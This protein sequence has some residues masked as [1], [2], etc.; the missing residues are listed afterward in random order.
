MQS[1]L[2]GAS[3]IQ[4]VWFSP[5]ARAVKGSS[6]FE[7]LLGA[8]PDTV[9]TNRSAPPGVAMFTATS[10]I[11]AVEHTVNI[12]EGRVDYFITPLITN[13]GRPGKIELDQARAVISKSVEGAIHATGHFES[14]VRLALV[15][16]LH[17][18]TPTLERAV[19]TVNAEAGSVLR[20]NNMT[21]LSLQVNVRKQLPE[22]VPFL[23]RLLRLSSAS[24]ITQRISGGAALD[25]ADTKATYLATKQIDLNSPVEGARLTSDQQ[26]YVWGQLHEETLRQ[27]AHPGFAGLQ[28]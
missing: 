26:K 20:L 12:A 19:E 4:L 15:T 21:E 22:A 2:W 13:D 18:E 1:D 14:I 3:K 11:D 10:T 6:V 5:D 7:K 16:T 28:D 17:C 25:F 8:E 27:M 24:V 9:Q 23:N